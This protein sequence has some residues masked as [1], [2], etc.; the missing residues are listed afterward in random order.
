VESKGKMECYYV[1]GQEP[2]KR[3]HVEVVSM[4]SRPTEG[5][6]LPFD[7]LIGNAEKVQWDESKRQGCLSDHRGSR[8]QRETNRVLRMH[9]DAGLG[10]R[11]A[12]RAKKSEKGKI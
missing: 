9:T 3:E 4:N 12:E 5:W 10:Q 7:L 6:S 8:S 2:L 11:N 1:W